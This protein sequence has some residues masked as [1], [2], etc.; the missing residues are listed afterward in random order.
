MRAA[1]RILRSEE[2]VMAGAPGETDWVKL[3]SAET[4]GQFLFAESVVEKGAG[5]PYHMHTHE[6]ELFY[7][8]EGEFLLVVGGQEH[9]VGSG[10][11]VWAPRNVPHRFE[12]LGEGVNRMVSL[13]TGTNFEAFFPKYLSAMMAGD[14]ARA[15]AVANEHGISFPEE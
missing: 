12:G 10:T 2:G 8:V 4:G 14:M 11:T 5:P 13:V 1:P 15:D 6:D 7:I 9:R 3:S